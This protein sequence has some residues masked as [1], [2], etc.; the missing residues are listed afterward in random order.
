M[1]NF[2]L[3]RPEYVGK[4]KCD[5]S[6]C[7]AACCKGWSI[8]IDAST[9]EKYLSYP[10]IVKHI[11]FDE[12][13]GENVI[14]LNE[15]NICPFLTEKKLCT[16]QLEHGEK[17]L[18]LVCQ[19]YPRIT[20]N[21]GKFWEQSLTPTCPVAAEMILFGRE[22][23]K[24][25]MVAVSSENLAFSKLQVPEKFVE[26]LIDIQVAEI[27][28]LQERTLTINQRLIMLRFFLDRLEEISADIIDETALTKLL[29]AYESK[30]FLAQQVPSMLASVHFDAKKF[31]GMMLNLFET[32]YSKMYVGDGRKFLNA[33]ADTLE[34]K[35]DEK[36]LISVTKV[37]A[38]YENLATE[39]K[40]FSAQYATFLENYLVNELFMNCYPWRF[41]ESITK[42]YAM[43]VTTYKIFE[44]LTFAAIH[45]GL[46]R[47]DDLLK[48]VDW[49]G[50][51]IDHTVG[52][53]Q[54][55]FDQIKNLDDPLTL[56]NSL[57]EQ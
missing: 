47:H 8:F 23:L 41:F 51:Q 19:N 56:M 33:V 1:G 16:L 17:F 24:F 29:A 44:L 43:F 4:F 30:N 50:S 20:Y 48:L 21:F 13:K 15:H 49:F 52:I 12:A 14:T 5:G 26:H 38:R 53:R 42:N 27:S 37:A 3:F 11:R 2:L 18:S 36:N 9:Y 54:K 10:Q 39:R 22:P 46:D 6:K 7:N 28:I 31:I 35:P 32:L 34:L 40:N 25:E 45:S 55:I 57:L